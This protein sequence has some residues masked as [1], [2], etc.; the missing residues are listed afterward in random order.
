MVYSSHNSFK[1]QA[2]ILHR[3][4]D[5]QK[6]ESNGNENV[7]IGLFSNKQNLCYLGL[8]LSKYFLSAV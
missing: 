3:F 8:T 5:Q 6:G 7:K 1:R 4:I 2:K